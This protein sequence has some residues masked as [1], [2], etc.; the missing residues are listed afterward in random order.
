MDLPQRL[1]IMVLG[2]LY[3]ALQIPLLHPLGFNR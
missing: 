1:G 2:A 3:Y